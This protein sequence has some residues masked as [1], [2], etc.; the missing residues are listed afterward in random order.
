MSAALDMADLIRTRILTAPTGGELATTL[1][2]TGLDVI[3]DRQVAI[4]SKIDVAVAKAKGTAVVI[5]WEGFQ[6]PD[7]N[8]RKPRLAQRYNIRVYSKQIIGGAAYPADDVLESIIQRLWHWV[9]VGV[10]AFGEIT[11]ENGDMIPDKSY[12]IYDC[13]VVIP[14]S[15]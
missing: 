4:L 8:T 14:V 5:F 15:L 10:H 11:V 9:P 12:L 6:V 1:N 2:L 7:A 13:E 3:I